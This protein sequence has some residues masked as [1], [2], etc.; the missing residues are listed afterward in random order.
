MGRLRRLAGNEILPL[1]NNTARASHP[2][3]VIATT[4]HELPRRLGKSAESVPPLWTDKNYST[5]HIPAIYIL[6]H[7]ALPPEM[8]DYDAGVFDWKSGPRA[9]RLPSHRC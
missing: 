8:P 3:L 1:I 6:I 4:A 5:K 2:R 9:A 7:H